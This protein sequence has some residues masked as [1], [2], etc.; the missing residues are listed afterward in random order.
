MGMTLFH[1]RVGKVPDVMNLYGCLPKP[2]YPEIDMSCASTTGDHHI[3][4]DGF[5]V[6]LLL[7]TVQEREHLDFNHNDLSPV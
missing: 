7:D 6:S 2:W 1:P 4:V 5:R 3:L